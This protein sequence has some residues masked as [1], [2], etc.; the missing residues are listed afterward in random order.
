[1]IFFFQIYSIKQKRTSS[2]SWFPFSSS[3][4]S[5]VC[6]CTRFVYCIIC[7]FCLW[8]HIASN[9][10]MFPLLF[11]HPCLVLCVIT[12]YMLCYCSCEFIWC[13]RMCCHTSQLTYLVINILLF[14]VSFAEH[15]FG[16][17]ILILNHESALKFEMINTIFLK[18]SVFYLLCQSKCMSITT[19]NAY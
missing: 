1:M 7:I 2:L 10:F 18:K 6:K 5:S 3:I 17:L 15:L 14:F 13:D 8:K 19:F 11:S 4:K 12:K 16:T 9:R